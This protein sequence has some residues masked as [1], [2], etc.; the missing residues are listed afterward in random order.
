MTNKQI[1]S[2]YF[3]LLKRQEKL[4]HAFEELTA[5][6]QNIK[7]EHT[8]CYEHDRDMDNGYGKW[9]KVKYKVCKI[10]KRKFY[11]QLNEWKEIRE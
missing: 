5:A 4:S 10:C 8:F 3:S 1:E 2:K 9:W 7:C 6:A 11:L